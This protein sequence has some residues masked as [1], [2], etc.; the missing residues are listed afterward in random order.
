VAGC[1]KT[2]FVHLM[3]SSF[4][5]RLHVLLARDSNI[6]VIIRRG[7]AKA[8]CTVVWNRATNEFT[9][10]QWMRGRIYERR[11]D[12]SPDGKYLIY[13][14]MNGRWQ[15]EAKGAWTAISRVPYLKAITLFPKGDCWVGGGLFTGRRNYWL[16]DGYGHEPALQESLEV[17]RDLR[18]V[19]VGAQGGECLSVY[20]PRLLRDGWTHCAC[21][22]VGPHES[23]DTFEKPITGGWMLR[24]SAHAQ[25]GSPPG[26]GCY[27]DEH[28]IVHSTGP[29]IACDDW[30]WADAVGGMLYWARK[31]RLHSGV[32]RK[33]AI[34]DEKLLF[35][36]NPMEFEAIAAPY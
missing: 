11:C 21:D 14:A 36:F 4:P 19:P 15:S 8:V 27:W 20:Y 3:T 2:R 23:V 16:N 28:R 17:K 10:G 32:V 22:K 30:E 6:G 7:P 26:K 9:V 24:K 12:V 29:T 34:A 33:G 35:D 31:G 18:F 5:A 13:F 1:E 25:I